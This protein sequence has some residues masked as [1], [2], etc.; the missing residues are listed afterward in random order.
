VLLHRRALMWPFKKRKPKLNRYGWKPD[1]PDHR[2]HQYKAVY[3]KLTGPFPSSVDLRSMCPPVQDQGDLGACSSHAITSAIEFLDLKDKLPLVMY[4]RLFVYYNERAIEGTT[5]SDS[6]AMLR[7][8]IKT[9]CDQ[10]VCPEDLWPYAIN[11][12]TNKPI[13]ACYTAALPHKAVSYQRLKSLE[14]MKQCLASGFP[15]IFGFT[16]YESFESDEVAK[17]GIVPMPS[18]NEESLGGHAVCCFGYDD[19]TKMAIV[20]NSWG[21]DWGQAGYFM[22]PYDYI[23]NDDLADDFW[24]IRKTVSE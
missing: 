7:D 3:K 13:D 21:P 8:G 6:G 16:V 10:G 14:D 22:L 20:R 12:F 11:I 9:M 19:K 17:T 1:L 24:T 23:S 5:G 18:K 2:D 4:S 15:F